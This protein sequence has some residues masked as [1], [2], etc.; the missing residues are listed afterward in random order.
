[1][2]NAFSITTNSGISGSITKLADG[3]S[4]LVAGPGVQI[5]SQSNGQVFVEAIASQASAIEFFTSSFYWTCPEN[6]HT[7][8]LT[9]WAGGGGGGGSAGVSAAWSAGGGGGG[10]FPSTTFVSVVPGN[11]YTG[12][13]G[14]GGAAGTS[15]TSGNASNGSSGSPSTFTGPSV[16][17]T[18]PAGGSGGEWVQ[19]NIMG[20]AGGLGQAPLGANGGRGGGYSSS[21]NGPGMPSL[22]GYLGGTT[23]TW[24]FESISPGGGGGAGPNGHGGNGAVSVTAPAAPANGSGAGGGGAYVQTTSPYISQP[25]AGGSGAIVLEWMTS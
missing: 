9:M 5:T 17:L 25:A 19:S 11:V 21:G 14:A 13:V 7:V 15:N 18:S 10:S 6:V 20:G 24:T 16:S 2:T 23:G 12:S 4:Y 8:K 3:S 1:M 22:Q